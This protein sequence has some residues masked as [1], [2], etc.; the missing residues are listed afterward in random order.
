[1]LPAP[2]LSG[3]RRA[4]LEAYVSEVRASLR[5]DAWDV[6]LADEWPDDGEDVY[7]QIDPCEQRWIATLRLGSGFW[8]LPPEDQRN[9]IVHELLHLHHVRLTDVT[10]LGA[11]RH[12]VGQALYD[13]L[14]DQVKREAELMVDALASVLAPFVPLPPAWPA[15]APG[16]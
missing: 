4:A 13:H 16:H 10:R 3:A 14:V 2:P 15:D 1:M 8:D 6:R 9:T 11:W 12:Q 7:A 5:L